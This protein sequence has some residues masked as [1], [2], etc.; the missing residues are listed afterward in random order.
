MSALKNSANQNGN[1]S[2]KTNLW[3]A[4]KINEIWD[5][6]SLLIDDVIGGSKE[7]FEI[8]KQ[9]GGHDIRI[10][11]LILEASKFAT[12]HKGF[13]R[14]YDYD[15]VLD[16]DA[17]RLSAETAFQL[18]TLKI[19]QANQKHFDKPAIK[20]YLKFPLVVREAI[21]TGI[22][23]PR[24]NRFENLNV[25]ILPLGWYELTHLIAYGL[26]CLHTNAS[27]SLGNSI[28]GVIVKILAN[29]AF[30]QYQ[31]QHP[32]WAPESQLIP[33]LKLD[34]TNHIIHNVSY[35]SDAKIVIMPDDFN[36]LSDILIACTESFVI[37]HE[38]GH[39]LL[40]DVYYQN[41]NPDEIKVD[42]LALKLL[43]NMKDPLGYSIHFPKE[44]IALLS[45]QSL[46]FIQ[47]AL[48]SYQ[49]ELNL[50][51][52]T[53]SDHFHQRAIALQNLAKSINLPLEDVERLNFLSSTMRT[54]LKVIKDHL[55]IIIPYK[56]QIDQVAKLR[57]NQYVEQGVDLI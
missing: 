44:G 3:T 37:A 6:N 20:E 30:I 16:K 2:S 7:D 52:N 11:K 45:A 40:G 56:A 42:D 14:E 18:R 49:I 35:L 10:Q 50:I 21:T 23:Q 33:L 4:A 51:D 8:F 38:I 26:Q 5:R 29:E 15:W 54:Y 53:E 9:G 31:D 34:L 32:T 27:N 55:K 47:N 57:L 17:Y 43:I 48:L 28:K 22:G 46:I 25:I 39:I 19:L 1:R 41:R 36:E 24:T 12:S 13:F